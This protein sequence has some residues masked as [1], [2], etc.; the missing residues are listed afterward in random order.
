MDE[1]NAFIDLWVMLLTDPRTGVLLLLL[2]VAAVHDY[3]T[4]RIPNLI[5]GGGVLFALSYNLLVPPEM[6]AD[7]SWGL[8]GMLV[9]VAVML[10]LYALNALGAG[11]VKLMMMVGAFL[12]AADTAYAVLFTVLTAGALALLHSMR[13]GLLLRLLVNVGHIARSILWNATGARLEWQLTP[14]QSVGRLAYGINIALGSAIYL[15]A[16]QFGLL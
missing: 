2:L 13:H 3:R 9:A 1:F 5:T 15:I 11:D 8:A 4:Y 6:H 10:P 16:H 14:V 12:G 7:W